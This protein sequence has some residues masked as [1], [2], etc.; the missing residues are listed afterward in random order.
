MVNF[1][2][3]SIFILYAILIVGCNNR[4][5]IKV[6]PT[7]AFFKNPKQSSYLISPDGETLSFLQ[8][9]K[10]R[11]NLFTKSVNDTMVVQISSN[12]NQAVKLYRWAGSNKIL[13][14]LDKDTAGN[15][16]VY[17]VNK[18]GSNLKKIDI[19]PKAKIQ[20]LGQFEGRKNYI[21]LAINDRVEKNFDVYKIDIL[22]GKKELY[23]KN[24]GNFVEWIADNN[25]EINMALA[26]DGVTETFFYRSSPSENFKPIISNDFKNTLIPIGSTGQK[27]HIYAL[28]NLNRDKLALV[29]FDCEQKKETRLLYENPA[30]D[31]LDVYYTKTANQLAYLT[32]EAEKSEILFLN[33]KFKNIFTKVRKKLR[34]QKIKII[35]TDLAEKHFILKT[36]T[37]K[38][39]GTY[40]LY[41]TINHKLQKLGE[42]NS[43]IN[44]EYMS[45]MK[46]I[47]YKNRDGKIINGYL[48]LPKG[49]GG[50]N[51]P[52]IVFPHQGPNTRTIWGYSPEVQ[53]LANKGYAVFQ[54]NYTGSIGYGKAFYTE[55]FKQWGKKIQND[56]TD[57]VKWLI[58][59][60]IANPSKI[61]IYGYGFGG[62][63]ALNQAVY[64]PKLYKC[65]ASYSGYINLFN[66][67]KGF[68]AYFKPEQE[69]LNEIIGNPEKDVEY[70]KY[71]SPIFQVEKINIPIFIAQGGKD[72]RVNVTETNHFV[73]ELR[74]KQLSVTYILKENET[75]LFTNPEVKLALYQQL[76]AFLDTHLKPYKR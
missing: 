30:V 73:K 66:Y 7:E 23:L 38:S 28:S 3:R 55:G 56:I 72:S 58:E 8:P 54:M 74:Q 12:Q 2:T 35:D 22:T 21:L 53:F 33:T 17:L 75:Q 48:T 51:L 11:L 70:L 13:Y 57:G 1:C 69:M 59:E 29:D 9:Y 36:Y 32:Y 37:D 14:M 19:A 34:Y 49:R 67:L 61:G 10:G 63:S 65:A 20:L 15:Y 45:E 50:Q 4:G 41:N 16:A 6:I 76:G 5:K 43:E 39:P 52:C 31:V 26:N 68:P 46:A 60:K 62:F 18:D 40:Y 25:G 27:N 47:C 42:L 24:P 44:P 64:Q 71:A